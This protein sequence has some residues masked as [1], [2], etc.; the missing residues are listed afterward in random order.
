MMMNQIFPADISGE[1]WNSEPVQWITLISVF[2]LAEL[3]RPRRPLSLR[4]KFASSAALVS[5]LWLGFNEIFFRIVP[6]FVI[7]VT[8]IIGS[9][10]YWYLLAH[11]YENQDPQFV[12]GSWLTAFPLS[13]F[14]TTWAQDLLVFMVIDLLLYGTHY[15]VHRLPILWN[16]HQVHHSSTSLNWLAGFRGHVIDNIFFKLAATLP[17]LIFKTSPEFVIIWG[18][19]DSVFVFFAHANLKIG[20]PSIPGVGPL[21]NS[22]DY[23][24]THHLKDVGSGCGQNFSAWFPLWDRIFK[25]QQLHNDPLQNYGINDADSGKLPSDFLG[26][27]VKPIFQLAQRKSNDGSV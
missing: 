24:A 3:L 2:T 16:F 9:L 23:H 15:W 11:F 4:Q 19:M 13:V 17:F 21:I 8:F 10:I 6:G 26:Q 5:S 12:F 7:K 27:L 25:T 22:P 14:E 20:S 1:M 18:W